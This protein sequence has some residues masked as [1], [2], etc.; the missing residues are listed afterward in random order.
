MPRFTTARFAATTTAA[1]VLLISAGVASAQSLYRRAMQR[2]SAP[3]T[4]A[5]TTNP[6]RMEFAADGQ[7]TLASIGIAVVLP[8]EPRSFQPNDLITILIAERSSASREQSLETEKSS[9]VSGEVQATIDLM[10]LLELRLEQGRIG[11][12]LP[13]WGV[14]FDRDF[15]GEGASES[16]VAVTARVTARVV[17][18]FPN[19]NLLLESRTT[20][21]TD[22]EEQVILLSGI[23][24]SEDISAQNTIQSSLLAD[25]NLNMQHA[26]PV[27]S[28]AQKGIVTRVM[29]TLFAF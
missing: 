9:N 20:V 29:D 12:S 23:A 18:V 15:E 24:R 2:P 5:R 11:G 25:L 6:E 10:K 26:G 14:T 16:E 7:P 28:A 22:E 3:A 8:P 21:V 1:G 4:D 19:G 27:K 17:E 13:E